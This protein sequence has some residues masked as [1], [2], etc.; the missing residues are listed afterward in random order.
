VVFFTMVAYEITPSTGF[1]VVSSNV[2]LGT[3]WGRFSAVF[4]CVTVF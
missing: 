4:C 2:E 3:Y 1:Q